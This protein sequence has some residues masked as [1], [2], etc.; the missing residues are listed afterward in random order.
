MK[1]FLKRFVLPTGLLVL[2]LFVLFVINE[3]A[4]VVAMASRINTL[5]GT[6]LLWF[7]VA[8]YCLLA[9]VPVVVFLRLPRSLSAP[10]TDRDAAFPAYLDQLRRRLAANSATRGMDLSG[11][12]GIEEALRDLGVRA[13]ETIQNAASTVFLS[14]AI[15]QNGRL[16]AF[17][18]LS[19]QSRMIWQ[20]AHLY[21]QRPGVRDLAA[22]YANV[23]A[24][25][26]IAGE[27]DDLDISEQVEPVISSVFGALTGSI[28]GFQLVA[29]ILVTSIL[30]GAANAFLT[31]RVGI[32]A[33]AYCGSLI[34]QEKRS[35]RRSAASQAAGLLGGIVRQGTAKVGKAV[36]E[37]SKNKVGG[38]F[39]DVTGQARSKSNAFL[40]K[41][42]IRKRKNQPEGQMEMD[43]TEIRAHDT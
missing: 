39:T 41:I 33:K 1:D 21:Y 17:L 31:L 15:S 16:D 20:I 3:T 9:A 12:T 11:R 19:A 6:V 7:L 35:L 34:A 4:Q 25:T 29:S 5:F 26:F 28:P 32:I 2:L 42:G 18:V 14:T 10:A 40:E 43:L 37:A 23:A 38:T 8:A 22:L 27:L 36:W 24:T 30:T 13:D